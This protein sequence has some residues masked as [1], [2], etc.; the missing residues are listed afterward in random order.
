[1]TLPPDHWAMRG[2]F[3]LDTET[4]G[5]DVETALIGSI[6]AG[7]LNPDGTSDIRTAYI[8][9]DMP[10]EAGAV[11][12]L[13]TAYLAE[14]GQ[15]APDVLDRFLNATANACR[16]GRVLVIANAPYDLTVID[17]ECRRHGVATLWQRLAATDT[18]L[19]VVDPIVLDKRA[20]KYRRRVSD[21][22][23]A[24]QLKTLAQ[25]HRCG[26]DDVLA[27]TSEYDALQAG[28]V[29]Y[30]LLEGF[31]MLARL[32]AGELHAYQ[33]A[34]YREQSESLASYFAIE[35]G[36]F[37]GDAARRLRDEDVEGARAAMMKAA[38]FRDKAVSVDTAWPYRPYPVP[39]VMES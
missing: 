26:W 6:S 22:Q 11:N 7:P 10:E 37:E 16:A 33:V 17:R 29:T 9:V 8:P 3:V 12:G 34:W 28:R 5:V 38:E 35:A 20:I 2:L 32:T 39:V 27:H 36:K 14:H 23:G 24:R 13:T 25:V 19:V 1:M 21:T 15:P 18:P 4:T 30:A 31:P